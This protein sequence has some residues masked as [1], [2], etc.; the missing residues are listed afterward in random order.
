[1]KSAKGSQ[2]EREFAKQL[3]VWWCGK[4]DAFWRTAGSGGRAKGRARRGIDTY[5][6]HGDIGSTRPEGDSLISL[7]CIELKRG[8]TG[9]SMQDL[10]D[11]TDK[12][13][14]N[15]WESWISQAT[16]SQQQSGSAFWMLVSKRDR[17][18]AVVTVELEFLRTLKEWDCLVGSFFPLSI[19]TADVRDLSSEKKSVM[20]A[21][22]TV[23]DFYKNICPN[24]L[25]D[26]ASMMKNRV[27]NKL[28]QEQTHDKI[29]ETHER[30]GDR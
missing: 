25:G 10:I 21:T 17:K 23:A 27:T 7:L 5:G 18:E 9:K 8:Y 6:Q 2:Y 30:A 22:F 20:I 15:A 19:L 1:M 29:D 28:K 11:R 12:T 13:K 24:K 26:L 3:G 16:E 14:P 4:E